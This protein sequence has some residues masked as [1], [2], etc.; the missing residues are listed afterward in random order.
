MA[1]NFI[2]G[3]LAGVSTA[4]LLQP[5]DVLKTSILVDAT[6]TRIVHNI[7]YVYSKYGIAGFWRG[8]SPGA[9]RAII[10]GGLN[11][12]TLEYLR[13]LFN[14]NDSLLNQVAN[15]SKAAVGSRVLTILVLC[16]LSVVKVRMEAVGS[17]QYRSIMHGL[18]TIATEEGVKGLYKGLI[19]N[20]IRD[21][22]F[23]A[24]A[25]SFFTQ[26]QK[27]LVKSLGEDQE[28]AVKFLSGVMAAFTAT[29][30]THPFDVVKTRLQ[31][32]H[33]NKDPSL[34][35]SGTLQGISSIWRK[36]GLIG[37]TRGLSIRLMEKS[38]SYGLIWSLYE[39]YK[40]ILQ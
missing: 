1:S 20:I 21:I 26:Y 40:R 36:E 2:A 14:N 6:R 7:T 19:P 38:I 18:Q 5:F 39:S 13:T 15:D 28:I 37:F 22:P 16:P 4:I 32:S 27:V 11:F 17:N 10:G 33:L 30:L 12:Y 35:Y 9:T 24:L 34:Q 23:S 3:S 25:F 29:M 31:Y 8:V